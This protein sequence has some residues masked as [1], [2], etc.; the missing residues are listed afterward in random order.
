MGLNG[1][2]VFVKCNRDIGVNM[3]GERGDYLPVGNDKN[4]TI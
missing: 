1:H 3:H 4:M 2:V